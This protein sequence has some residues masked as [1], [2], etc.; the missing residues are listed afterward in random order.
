M[1]ATLRAIFHRAKHRAPKT[2]ET[3]WFTYGRHTMTFQTLAEE[4]RPGR[5]RLRTAA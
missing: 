3:G 1:Y 2:A 4:Q 5:H